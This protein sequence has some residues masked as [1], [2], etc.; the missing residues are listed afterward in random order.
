MLVV[1]GITVWYKYPYDVNQQYTASSIDGTTIEVSIEVKGCRNLF[2]P[3]R[4]VGVMKVNDDTYETVEA[5]K[6]TSFLE[7]LYMKLEGD[8]DFPVFLTQKRNGD[9]IAYELID[10]VWGDS[11]FEEIYFLFIDQDDGKY[12]APARNAI[13][14]QKQQEKIFKKLVGE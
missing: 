7:R 11:G 5:G 1:L 9:E 12:F 10:I 4:Y 6:N 2:S 8:E 14:A 13:E 3:N